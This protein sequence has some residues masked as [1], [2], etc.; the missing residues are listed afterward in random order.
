MAAMGQKETK[1]TDFCSE[2]AIIIRQTLYRHIAPDGPLRQDGLKV[3]E[4]GKIR[5]GK[6]N[7][8][9]DPAYPIGLPRFSVQLLLR[10]QRR[11]P[12]VSSEKRPYRALPAQSGPSLALG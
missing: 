12:A 4:E 11:T 2:L 1:V 8:C 7:D 10:P 3:V 9:R 5:Y 6:K